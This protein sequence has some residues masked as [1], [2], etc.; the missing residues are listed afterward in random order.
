[1]DRYIGLDAHVSSCTLIRTCQDQAPVKLKVADC[2][3]GAV[4]PLLAN[5]YLHYGAADQ[6][7]LSSW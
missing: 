2:V 5:L 7:C 6:G 3:G 4:S 1:M